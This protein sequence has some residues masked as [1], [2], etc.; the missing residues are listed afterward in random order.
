MLITQYITKKRVNFVG[1]E[2]P[3]PVLGSWEYPIIEGHQPITAQPTNQGYVGQCNQREWQL[4]Y[5]WIQN[6][7]YQE[8]EELIGHKQILRK[9]SNWIPPNV[10]LTLINQ[11][12]LPQMLY[13]ENE[14]DPWAMSKTFKPSLH[15]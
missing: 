7:L 10:T 15:H 12:F 13:N 8:S 6:K 3:N 1:P 9:G 2:A 4:L 14:V 11:H 5:N